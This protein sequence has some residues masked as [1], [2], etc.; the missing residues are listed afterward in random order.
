MNTPII[1]IS[2][3]EV[4]S[5]AGTYNTPRRLGDFI[6]LFRIM[7]LQNGEFSTEDSVFAGISKFNK[8]TLFCNKLDWK[9]YADRL[10]KQL[11]AFMADDFDE[12][13]T[14]EIHNIPSVD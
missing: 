7:K 2:N 13:K 8:D 10:T 9:P 4:T 12:Q 11:S 14:I 1:F 6:E 3:E 5:A